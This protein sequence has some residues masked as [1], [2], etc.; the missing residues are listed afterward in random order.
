MVDLSELAD[1][2]KNRKRNLS[3][4][5]IQDFQERLA[6]LSIGSADV[7]HLVEFV[8]NQNKSLKAAEFKLSFAERLLGQYVLDERLIEK[9]HA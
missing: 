3:I 8:Q 9:D 2:L 4:D 1:G 5:S 6:G 7:R